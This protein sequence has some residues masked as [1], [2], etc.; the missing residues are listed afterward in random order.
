M[1]TAAEAGLTDDQWN[2][3]KTTK[4]S[5]VY[6]LIA[7][8]WNPDFALDHTLTNPISNN[9]DSVEH[10]GTIYRISDGNVEYLDTTWQTVSG[11]TEPTGLRNVPYSM[12]S[13]TDLYV[14]AVTTAGIVLATY[15]GSSWSSWS[16]I[17]SDVNV[18]YASAVASNRVHYIVYDS[19][20][21]RYSFKV[22]KYSGSW[23]ATASNIHYGYPIYSFDAIT[24]NSKDLL[25]CVTEVPGDVSAQYINNAVVKYTLRS[26]GIIGFSYQYNSWSDHY[27]V[28]VL[29]QITQYAYR[30]SVRLTIIN[31][32]VW[33][34]VYSSIGDEVSALDF[35]RSYNSKDGY[36]WSRGEYLPISRVE[37]NGVK[38]HLL[39]DD[40]YAVCHNAIYKATSTLK[41]DHSPTSQQLD[42]SAEVL[43]LNVQRQDMQQLSAT[44]DISS[45]WLTDSILDGTHEV[46]LMLY[47]GYVVGGTPIA[48]KVGTFEV[49]TITPGEELPNTE[50]DLSARDYL[51][52][53]STKTQAETFRYWEPQT[54]YG[55]E[56]ID[57]TGTGYGGMGNTAI[58]TGSWMTVSNELLETD[59]NLEGIVFNT[60]LDDNTW[61]GMEQVGFNLSM[62]AN[63]E[64]A[65]LI[66]RAQ[67]VSNGFFYH[68]SQSL[69]KTVFYVLSAG[70]QTVLWTSGTK[71]W[72][73]N[74]NTRYLRVD[75][76]Y[77][78]ILLYYSD[79]GAT[80]TLD[81]EVIVDGQNLTTSAEIITTPDGQI[82]NTVAYIQSGFAGMLAKGFSVTQDWTVDPGAAPTA[83]LSLGVSNLYPN[84]LALQQ[85]VKFWGVGYTLNG[86][87]L[88]SDE[89]LAVLSL[90]DTGVGAWTTYG[91]SDGLDNTAITS[92]VTGQTNPF[93]NSE[94]WAMWGHSLFKAT[95]FDVSPV[96]TKIAIPSDIFPSLSSNLHFTDFRMSSFS[97][98][99]Y[100]VTA[101]L[102]TP[103]DDPGVGALV[104][105]TNDGGDTWNWTVIFE[106]SEAGFFSRI[107][108][109]GWDDTVYILFNH[110]GFGF[111]ASMI[112]KSTDKAQTWSQV[113]LYDYY[114]SIFPPSAA[115]YI[116]EINV[117]YRLEDGTPNVNGSLIFYISTADDT[118]TNTTHKLYRS[119]DGGIT[120]TF[121]SNLP[122]PYGGGN[123]GPSG[124][125]AITQPNSNLF[126]HP[127]SANY[128]SYVSG[129]KIIYSADAGETW[130][131]IDLGANRVYYVGGWPYSTSF[132][133]SVGFDLGTTPHFQ[134][135]YTPDD[136]TITSLNNPPNTNIGTNVN[137]F[138]G[139]IEADI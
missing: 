89:R 13:D 125:G 7:H 15:D 132:L 4:E 23:S 86:S 119:D 120:Q 43:E 100:M 59:N 50:V 37:K 77:C 137:G 138:L 124:G 123:S 31:G 40:I 18:S 1:I 3:L 29:D 41:F 9:F 95:L 22:A 103:S 118:L 108:I 116:S 107:Q 63:N 139:F 94:K 128:Q 33:L 20:H 26:G 35:Y 34:T 83:I 105:H 90:D 70:T 16:T 76:N 45:G 58:Q 112:F 39:G 25:L 74:L 79:D 19:T 121:V 109:S 38:V 65:G 49:D 97:K 110:P 6:Q 130:T 55:D 56:F 36:H 96:I 122:V 87:H 131:Q 54:A 53:M 11:F 73:G 27:V 82:L 21:F 64:L 30:A 80:W 5:A 42:I 135:V 101:A 98:D 24:L 111:E 66:F 88:P 133:M 47:M 46:M 68:Y 28:D 2:A 8:K 129:Q 14:F 78:R 48:I 71:S 67:D 99:F 102:E 60:I 127:T 93:K 61:N 85:P 84:L 117:P 51:A 114:A 10:A 106:A 92:R 32:K 69:D 57:P 91:S 52:W 104:A 62:L 81:Q 75:Y 115:G 134:A 44:L 12:I 17:I 136:S 113:Y 126:V 72:S